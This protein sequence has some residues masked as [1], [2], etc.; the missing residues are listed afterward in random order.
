MPTAIRQSSHQG[1]SKMDLGIVLPTKANSWEV[2]VRAEQLGFSHAWF[3][4]TPLLN[5]ELFAAMAVAAV[6]TSRIK[7]GSG[8]MV[9]SLRSAPVAAS[10]LATLNALA[11]GRIVFGVSTGFTGRNTMGLKPLTLAR[12]KRYIEVVRGLLAG[13]TVEWDEEGGTHK[14]RF[15]NP[16]AGLINISDDIPVAI[17]AFGPKARAMVAELGTYWINFPLEPDRDGPEMEEMR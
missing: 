6:K 14:I 1:E 8:V 3:Y 12:M 15:L 2:V 4:D 13:E 10:G 16:D 7:L 9:P 11:P 17:S 5:A